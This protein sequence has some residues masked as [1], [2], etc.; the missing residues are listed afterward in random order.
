M[1][2]KYGRI[3]DYVYTCR[4]KNDMNNITDKIR[5]YKRDDY[6]T[7][8]KSGSRKDKKPTNRKSKMKLGGAGIDCLTK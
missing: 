8:F 5:A 7:E 1:F 6:K 3:V 4:N 2:N